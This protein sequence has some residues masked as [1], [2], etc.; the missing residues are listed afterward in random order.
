MRI[1][2]ENA[3]GTD[4]EGAFFIFYSKNKM[5]LFN[6]SMTLRHKQPTL[7]VEIQNPKEFSCLH[8]RTVKS[9]RE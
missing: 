5:M 2:K 8:E 6:V 9:T 7:Y 3:L 4:N 1:K